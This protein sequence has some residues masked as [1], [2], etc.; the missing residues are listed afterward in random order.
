M[1][2]AWLAVKTAA[3]KSEDEEQRKRYI[4]ADDFAI[5]NFIFSLVWSIGASIK[6][7]GREKLDIYLKELLAANADIAP[8]S[9]FCNERSLYDWTLNLSSKK[10][11][12]Q[13][14]MDTVPAYSLDLKKT[15]FSKIIVPTLDGVR[16]NAIVRTLVQGKQHVLVVGNTGTGKS[17]GV[18]DQLVS[19]DADQ[20]MT[21]FMSFSAST[22]ANQ[23]Q[24]ILDSKFDKRRKGVFGPPLGKHFVIFVD[25]CSRKVFRTA[26]N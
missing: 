4:P 17:L 26:S 22:S 12:W 16:N 23:T 10:G 1:A 3:E 2:K 5:K 18:V 8:S 20:F 21:A 11:E 13:N 9:K 15:D 19:L 6:S 25:A 14:W 7:D 24:D